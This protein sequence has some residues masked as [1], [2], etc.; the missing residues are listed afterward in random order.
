MKKNSK[1]IIIILAFFSLLYFIAFFFP[2]AKAS[3]NV[4]M[5]AVFEPDEKVQF[6]YLMDMLKPANTI[7]QSL[8]NFA[9][10]DYYFYGYPFFAFSGLVLLPIKALG[11]L[12]NT[13]LVMLI[14]RQMISMLPQLIAILLL[15]YM[16]TE[17]KSYKAIVVFL[18]LVSVPAVMQN[19]FWWHP[20]GL[21]ILLITFAIFFLER[22]QLRFS[23]N[24]FLTAMMCGFA[25]GTKGTGFFFFL[26]I[27][28][29]FLMGLFQKK[30]TLLKSIQF[31]FLFL[32]IMAFSYLLANPILIFAGVRE[33]Y[34]YV[35]QEEMRFLTSGYEIVVRTGLRG[36]WPVFREHF[37]HWIIVPAALAACLWGIIYRKKPLLNTIILSWFIPLSIQVFFITHF[38]FQYWLPVALPLFSCLAAVLPEKET[39]KNLVNKGKIQLKIAHGFSALILAI[40]LVQFVEYV[41]YSINRFQT[42]LHRA[43]DNPAIQFYFDAKQALEPLQ[44]E[45]LYIL[46]DVRMYMPTTSNWQLESE[47]Y[48]LNHE[49]IQSKNYDVLMILQQRIN[50]YTNPN[51]Q[52]IDPQSFAEYKRF[53]HDADDGVIP[54]YQLVFRNA[55]GLIFVR[56]SLY[57]QYF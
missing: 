44:R 7:K 34:F 25:A 33:R 37:R 30:I 3:E 49:Y 24:Y 55:Y 11:L 38:K 29:Y 20:D 41:P 1:A 22:D 9:F 28:V 51:A 35:M 50:D 57:D 23:K 27:I 48:L 26:A 31:A 18:F 46:H 32:F 10:Y 53:Y 42:Q 43:E 12:S 40:F 6:P 54:N 8:I 19:N 36:A 13:P 47:F 4:A 56:S 21:A 14:L 15:V 45:K 2:N 16:Q 52:P 39:L 5:V 17:F